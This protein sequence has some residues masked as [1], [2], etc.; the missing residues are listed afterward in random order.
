MELITSPVLFNPEEH[1]YRYGDIEL[2]GVTGML[3]KQIFPDMYAGIDEVVLRNAALRGTAIHNAV[4]AWDETAFDDHSPEVKNY[5][6]VTKGLHHEASEYIV[7]DLKHFASAIDKVYRVNDNTFVLADIKT[8]SELNTEYVQWQL[9]IY[10]TLFERQNPGA[11]VESL[12]AIWLR[13]NKGKMVRVSRIEASV[14]DSLLAA[15][16]E[17]RKF[18]NPF[19]TTTALPG[20]YSD[21]V[22]RLTELE[23]RLKTLT[24]ER[25]ALK[26]QVLDI[27]DLEQVKTWET[28][29][30]RLTFSS[31][32]ERMAFD[33]SAFKAE[34]AELYGKYVKVTQTKPSLRITLK[35]Q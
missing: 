18:D 9:S 8:T 20:C 30:V 1:T 34:N 4:Q 12:Q 19:A 21:K 22:A 32:S 11:K 15:E 25:D 27:M 24:A 35:N 14:I 33:Q 31:A 5:R 23:N 10:A 7:S 3:H 16:I 17:G 2:Q 13:G 28:D 29:A 6:Y 26:A